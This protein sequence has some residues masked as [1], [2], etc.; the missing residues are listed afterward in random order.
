MKKPS[1]AAPSRVLCAIMGV[2]GR[3]SLHRHLL[4][5][6]VHHKST[7]LCHPAFCLL[8]RVHLDLSHLCV[9][10]CKCYLNLA[11]TVT[12]KL[13]PR[14]TVYVFLGYPMEQKGYCC[15]NLATNQII[16]SH[17]VLFDESSFPF[18]TI[19]DPPSSSFDFL[20]EFNCTPL[21]IGAN[22]LTGTFSRVAP[23]DPTPVE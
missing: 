9:F 14:S 18:V 4:T 12:H 11:A 21:P 15:L 20:S 8:R 1:S 2:L 17:H 6:L 3:G 7:F 19:S 16:I 5:Q 13:T 22:P 10:G 23:V